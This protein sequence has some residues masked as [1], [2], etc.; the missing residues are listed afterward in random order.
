[1]NTDKIN[2][3]FLEVLSRKSGTELAMVQNLFNTIKNLQEQEYVSDKELLSL[4]RQ[5]QNFY[6]NKI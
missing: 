4:N 6:K 5:V 3:D 2:N 1:M